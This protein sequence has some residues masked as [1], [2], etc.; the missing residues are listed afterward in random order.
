M[1]IWLYILYILFRFHSSFEHPETEML[2]KTSEDYFFLGKC[3]IL[4]IIGFSFVYFIM[5]IINY[6][7]GG[8]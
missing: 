2:E 1:Y 6:S 5:C 8:W 4:K 3:M 7:K